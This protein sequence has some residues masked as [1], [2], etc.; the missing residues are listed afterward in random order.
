MEKRLFPFRV[1]P[2]LRRSKNFDRFSPLNV[3]IPLKLGIHSWTI[4]NVFESLIVLIFGCSHKEDYIP[5]HI[6]TH[7]CRVDPSD[8]L[9]FCTSLFSKRVALRKHAYTTILNILPPKN[10]KIQIKNSDIFHISA[11][12]IDCGYSLEPPRRGGSNEYPQSMFL[13]RN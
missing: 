6:L 3:S 4:Y 11:Q 8:F 9:T 7:S 12:N 2:F 10:E 5:I 1:D 13:G